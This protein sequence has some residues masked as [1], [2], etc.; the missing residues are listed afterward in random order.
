MT[1][2]SNDERVLA[3]FLASVRLSFDEVLKRADMQRFALTQSLTR[4]V[5]KGLL[6]KERV[7]GGNTAVT[8]FELR[9]QA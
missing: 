2:I 5:D 3:L 7:R 1:G 4:L 9:K 8:Y 6:R